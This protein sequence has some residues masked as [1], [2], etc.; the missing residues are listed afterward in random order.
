MSIRLRLTLWYSGILAVTLL[1]F[2]TALYIF[3]WQSQDSS[4][5]GDLRQVSTRIMSQMK[6]QPTVS[7]FGNVSYL[8]RLPSL[9]EYRFANYYVQVFDQKERLQE[10]S[11]SEFPYQAG[12]FERIKSLPPDQVD[13][14]VYREAGHQLLIISR[15]LITDFTGESTFIGMIQVAVSQD[16]LNKLLRNL[17]RVLILLVIVVVI[18]G[19]SLGLFLA[20]KALRPI[21]QVITATESIEKGQDLAKRIEYNGPPDEIG[22]LTDKINSM[23]ERMEGAYTE[24]EDAYRTQR[25]FVSDASHELRTPL[26]T[27]RGNVDLLEKMWSSAS[28]GG[29]P[30]L[31]DAEQMQMSREAMQDI[32][33]EAARMSRLVSDLLSL[34]R[35]DAGVVVTKTVVPMAPV[36]E[37]VVRRAG[38]LPKSVDWR[39]GDLDALQGAAVY[40]NEDYLQQLLFIFI[41]NAFKYTDEGWVQIDALRTEAQIGIRIS[42]TGIGM[43]KEDIPHIFDRFYRADKSRGQKAGTGLGLSI[44]KWIIDEHGG[45]IEVVTRKGEGSTFTIWLPL[46]AM[47]TLE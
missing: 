47:P 32:A 42:D 38:L 27:I 28:E 34:A 39:I 36:V 6:M 4:Q 16:E 29:V 31:P 46:H 44:A 15:P 10:A 35:A 7:F 23:L 17:L 40:G 12:T 1:L 20:R 43:D 5:R 8:L 25:R 11:N 37:Q 33:G 30:R 22:L 9:N 45:S 24:L 2:G 13:Y 21:E 26:T 14:Q 3:L 19:L 18:I 41:E